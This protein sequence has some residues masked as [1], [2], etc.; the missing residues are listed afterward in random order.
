MK[1]QS[2]FAIGI[3]T[4]NRM[5]LLEETINKYIIDFPNTKIYILDNG[6]QYIRPTN[7]V[8]W[9]LT[10]RIQIIRPVA[11]IGVAASWNTLINEIFYNDWHPAKKALIMNDDIYLGKP[12]GFIQ[13]LFNT[14][15]GSPVLLS[16]KQWSVFSIDSATFSAI[17]NFDERFFPAYYEDSDYD[18]RLKLK[19]ITP[20]ITDILDP[21]IYQQSMSIAKDTSLNKNYL[22]NR[23]FYVEKWGGEPG[24]EK[25]TEPFNKK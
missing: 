2:D 7:I 8:H 24:Q 15:P 17:G 23:D 13:N 5:D 4:I 12:E 14:Y 22:K 16:Q 10:E 19:G 18:Y 25:Y 21:Q 1:I 20:L 9:I 6:D 11:N 3:P